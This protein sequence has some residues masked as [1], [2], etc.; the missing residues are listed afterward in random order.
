MGAWKYPRYI[1][2]FKEPMGVW[3]FRAFIHN[4]DNPILSQN[5][6]VTFVIVMYD[7]LLGRMKRAP[8]YLSM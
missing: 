8:W 7:W 3:K 4:R 5:M 2:I 6:A 1:R